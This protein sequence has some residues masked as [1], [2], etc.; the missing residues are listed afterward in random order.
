MVTNL[1]NTCNSLL[2]NIRTSGL[3]FN[4]QE[5]PFSIYVTLRKSFVQPRTNTKSFPDFKPVVVQEHFTTDSQF[6]EVK[7]EHK[8]QAYDNV[9]NDLEDA[10][11]ELE[12]KNKVIEDLEIVKIKQLRRKSLK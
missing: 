10:I 12:T 5:T 1:E 3:N 7:V 9:K 8:K 11:D 6:S 2:Q 4:C